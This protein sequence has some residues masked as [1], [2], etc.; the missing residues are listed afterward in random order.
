MFSVGDFARCVGREMANLP[1]AKTR[2][3]NL[4]AA[5]DDRGVKVSVIFLDRSLDL[6]S[7]VFF[8]YLCS[9]IISINL[10]I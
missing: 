10:I 9:F 2:R 3:R 5:A 1:M 8:Q 4:G 6:A 7:G